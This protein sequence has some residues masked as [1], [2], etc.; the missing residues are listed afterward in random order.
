MTEVVHLTRDQLKDLMGE[1]VDDAFLRMGLDTENPLDMQRD[2]QH[3]RDW[4]IAVQ[5]VTSKG[6][7]SVVLLIISGLVAAAWIGIKIAVTKGLPPIQ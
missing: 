4:R 2:M 1:A 3:L 6:M 5:S 7:L